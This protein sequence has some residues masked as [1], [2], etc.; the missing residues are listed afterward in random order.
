MKYVRLCIIILALYCYFERENY[1]VLKFHVYN[2][3]YFE[4][5]AAIQS[6]LHLKASKLKKHQRRLLE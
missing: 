1:K 6:A 3:S 2:S 4:I 5:S